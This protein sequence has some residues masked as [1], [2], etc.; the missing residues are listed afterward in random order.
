MPATI[1]SPDFLW[2]T[3]LGI[4]PGT[5]NAIWGSPVICNLSLSE[6]G[7]EVIIKA[8]PPLSGNTDVHALRG[9]DGSELWN[10]SSFGQDPSSPA[11]ADIDG[12][13][14]DEVITRTFSD[15]LKALDGD[16]SEIWTNS[17]PGYA[18][19]SP[20]VADVDPSYPGPEILVTGPSGS[21]AKLWV[22]SSSGTTI[23]S[24]T[25]SIMEQPAGTPAVGDIDLD[26]Q[27]E[28]VIPTLFS[29][30][31]SVDPVAGSVEWTASGM[32]I[33]Q[34]P[35]I[36]DYDSDGT[37]DVVYSY[38][39][40]YIQVVRGTDGSPV[41]SSAFDIGAH[42]SAAD[43]HGVLMEHYAVWDTD[44]DGYANIFLGDGGDSSNVASH[45]LHVSGGTTPSL[46]WL[47]DIPQWSYDGGGVLADVDNDRDWDFIKTDDAG[48]LYA[49]DANTGSLVWR[50]TFD[51]L[52][53]TLDPAIAVGD[54]DGDNCSE[55]VVLGYESGLVGGN[56]KARAIDQ[57]GGGGSG[58]VPLSYDDGT[59]V[60]ERRITAGKLISWSGDRPV[61]NAD[62]R[63]YGRDGK[64]VGRF[65]AGTVLDL[66]AGV[67][68]VVRKGEVKRVVVR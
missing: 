53:A 45:L 42:T 54:V 43:T 27:V 67:Y 19:S 61:L 6:P 60:K 18:F 4:S 15:G 34:T 5:P 25:V 37:P 13:G 9:T 8:N 56:F 23:R 68:Y 29:G 57:S 35:I 11:C 52:S 41:W 64:L 30:L 33:N 3:D 16:G 46:V 22:I 44:G 17:D 26:G 28:V 20:V 48:Y 7:N 24:I 2:E 51:E 10:F 58:C 38:D 39:G 31:L 21:T 12:D 1:T 65:P 50:I 36:I 55:I 14:L 32:A 59:S 40:R 47:Y 62:A 63:V 66:P 49:I